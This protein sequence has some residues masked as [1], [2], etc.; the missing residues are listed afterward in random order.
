MAPKAMYS[1]IIIIDVFT[2]YHYVGVGNVVTAGGSTTIGTHCIVRAWESPGDSQQLILTYTVT[3]YP[4]AIPKRLTLAQ[5]CD[6]SEDLR[7]F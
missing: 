3:T 5:S 1:T 2:S 4:A 7:L 6:N